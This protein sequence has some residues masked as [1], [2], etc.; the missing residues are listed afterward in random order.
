MTEYM[1][2][3]LAKALATAQPNAHHDD[4]MRIVRAQLTGIH[5]PNPPSPQHSPFQ[6]QA[7]VPDPPTPAP[8]QTNALGYHN[9]DSVCHLIVNFHAFRLSLL[10]F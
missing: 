1:V 9:P 2:N 4:V 6:Q 7:F 8:A 5:L 3:T 10:A